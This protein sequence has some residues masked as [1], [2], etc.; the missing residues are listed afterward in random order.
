MDK[1]AREKRRL[2]IRKE[3]IGTKKCP[4]LNVFR[5]NRSIY[6]TLIDDQEGKTLLASS[7]RDIGGSAKATKTEKAFL[8]GK[9]L[10]EKARKGGFEKIVFDRAGYLYHGRVK[11]LAEGAREAGLKF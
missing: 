3:T 6:A 11:R 4:R 7:E 1:T 9:L 2:S 5:S 8:V 10:G